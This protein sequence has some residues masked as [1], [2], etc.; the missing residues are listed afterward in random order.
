MLEQAVAWPSPLALVHHFWPLLPSADGS[1]PGHWAMARA[2]CSV[3]ED[4]VLLARPQAQILPASELAEVGA[5]T[6]ELGRLLLHHLPY[7]DAAAR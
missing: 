1:L 3:A 7:R 2:L 4:M 6:D 5:H